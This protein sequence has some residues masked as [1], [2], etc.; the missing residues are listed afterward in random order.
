MS[1]LA[2]YTLLLALTACLLVRCARVWDDM[3]T[4]LLLVVLMFLATS[5]TFDEVLVMDP[6]RGFICYLGGFAFAVGVSELVLRGIRLKLPAGF[7]VPYYLILA[8]FFLYPLLLSPFVDDPHSEELL[9]GLFGFSTVAGLVFLTLLPALRRGA[10]YVRHNGSPWPWP[11]YP[12]MLFG[13]LACAVPARAFLLCWSM[14]IL[15]GPDS[16]GGLV[17]GTYFLVPFGFALGV[18]L[19]QAGLISGSRL[20]QGAALAAPIGLV[21]L[22]QGGQQDADI[23]REFL[24]LFTLRLG[25]SPLYLTLLAAGIFYLYAALRRV[26]A[27]PDLLTGALLTLCFIGPGSTTIRDHTPLNVEP[28]L[29]ASSVR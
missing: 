6:Q 24:Q 22:T 26:P 5:V 16:A 12:W 21:L 15:E 25:G 9:W 19:L 14:H 17:F 10:D 2:G 13:V 11:L 20:L 7:R 18:L 3:R 8:L 29:A 27:A 1:G 4:V 28:L 23:Y